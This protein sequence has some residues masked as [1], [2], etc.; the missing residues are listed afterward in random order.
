MLD[1][2]TGEFMVRRDCKNNRQEVEMA[3]QY[4]GKEYLVIRLLPPG[5][6]CT[7]EVLSKHTNKAKALKAYNAAKREKP[8]LLHRFATAWPIDKTGRI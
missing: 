8:S 4:T 5:P 1:M 7:E 3:N 6:D 2:T